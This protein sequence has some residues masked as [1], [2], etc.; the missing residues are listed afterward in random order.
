MLKTASGNSDT[1]LGLNKKQRFARHGGL[2]RGN[3][4]FG[5]AQ[6]TWQ[7]R[8]P[9]MHAEGS[10]EVVTPLK[11]EVQSQEYLSKPAR[12]SE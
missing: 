1:A 7:I 2:P 9:C 12:R 5:E 11:S 4:L 3:V 8:S 10:G 6:R